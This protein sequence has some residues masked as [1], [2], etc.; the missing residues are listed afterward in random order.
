MGAPTQDTWAEGLQL[1]LRMNFKFPNF[2]PTPLKKLIPN[3]SPQAIEFLQLLLQYDPNKRPTAAEALEHPF[4][5]NAGS[6]VSNQPQSTSHARAVASSTNRG[7]VVISSPTRASNVVPLKND[8]DEVVPDQSVETVP[9]QSKPIAKQP[10]VRRE[11][12]AKKS[13]GNK[14]ILQRLSDSLESGI[15]SGPKPI[16]ARQDSFGRRGSGRMKTTKL[17][18]T[19]SKPPNDLIEPTTT[20]QSYSRR[21]DGPISSRERR[22]ILTQNKSDL[23][24]DRSSRKINHSGISIGR[25]SK[26][27]PEA[28]VNGPSAVSRTSYQSQR[29]L[30]DPKNQPRAMTEPADALSNLMIGSGHSGGA[31]YGRSG[32][33][34]STYTNGPRRRASQDSTGSNGSAENDTKA[35]KKRRD[36]WESMLAEMIGD[37]DSSSA[38]R[39]NAKEFTRGPTTGPA[40]GGTRVEA[41]GRKQGRRRG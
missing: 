1:A 16:V 11:L 2:S 38:E 27:T 31:V 24:V 3:A 40:L 22:R 20:T 29:P 37:P 34:F 41:V 21:S 6:F 19:T 18:Q 33:A 39:A 7:T 30:A 35:S 9:N 32:F 17:N 8:T 26:R 5:K 4:L 12:S 28:H 13:S 25:E 10:Q 14:I 15:E 23:S 36:S